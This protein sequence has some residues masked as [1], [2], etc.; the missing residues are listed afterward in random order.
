MAAG[1]YE[2]TSIVSRA[3]PSVSLYAQKRRQL[4]G[5][6]PDKEGNA[7]KEYGQRGFRTLFM[8][9]TDYEKKGVYMLI[10]GMP[11][12]PMQIVRAHIMREDSNYMRDYVL[13]D[14]GDVKELGFHDVKDKAINS[15]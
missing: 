6:A 7:M 2:G 4:S 10:N 5:R 12:S 15:P 8:E 9:L 1:A 3:F 11:A 14:K 13:N